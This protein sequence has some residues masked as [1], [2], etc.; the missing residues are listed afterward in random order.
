MK[1]TTKIMATSLLA[2]ALCVSLIAGS[3][4]ALF[5]SEADVNIAITSGKVKLTASVDESSL[6]LYSLEN[7]EVDG[8]T[9]TG[10]GSSFKTGGTVTIDESGNL[11]LAKI[12]PG[13]RAEF[14]INIV[15]ESSVAI[16]YRAKIRCESGYKLYGMLE[17]KID[18]VEFLN[19]GDWTYVEAGDSIDSVHVSIG[20]PADA[21]NDAQT[22]ETKIVFSVSAIQGN[23]KTE[24]EVTGDAVKESDSVADLQDNLATLGDGEELGLTGSIDVSEVDNSAAGVGALNGSGVLLDDGADV[25]VDGNGN[26]ITLDHTAFNYFDGLE[27]VMSGEIVFK[28][29]HFKAKTPGQGYAV[30]LGIGST[31]HVTFENCLFEDLYAAIVCNHHTGEG[32]LPQITIRNCEYINT[33]WGYSVDTVS[34]TGRNNPCPVEEVATVIWENNRGDYRA[35]QEQFTATTVESN[36]AADVQDAL[37]K[38]FDQATESGS[39]DVD[40]YVDLSGDLDVSKDSKIP[41]HENYGIEV[42]PGVDL[43]ID[44]KGQTIT[45]DHTA[46][47]YFEGTEGIMSGTIV[48]RNVHFVG[49]NPSGQQGYA[50]TLGFDSTAHVIFENCTFEN[51]HSAVYCN[52]NDEGNAI[53]EIRGCTFINTA[54]VCGVT[55]PSGTSSVKLV[56]DS[57]TGYTEE[58]IQEF[59]YTCTQ[60]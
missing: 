23:G 2:I 6:T 33:T 24:D 22:L 27:G 18:D 30:V 48:I 38:A 39:K 34:L 53:V 28:N 55:A 37:D 45:L 16:K 20:L 41:N 56:L 19:W 7:G 14:D 51:M 35:G 5:T 10:A 17:K 1:K 3:T 54:F 44:G 8:Y 25:T 47:N 15:N 60:E 4:F 32:E 13:D 11:S 29:V 40:V 12:V 31:A 50:L 9:A 21:K 52:Q 43:T 49:S 36:V 46:F 58:Q 59:K 26:T 42:Q 57:S